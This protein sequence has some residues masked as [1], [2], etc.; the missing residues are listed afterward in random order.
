MTIFFRVDN[1]STLILTSDVDL[2][3]INTTDAVILKLPIDLPEGKQ[4]KIKSLVVTPNVTVQSW[5]GSTL[6]TPTNEITI[7]EYTNQYIFIE[8]EEGGGGY[9]GWS[10]NTQRTELDS[11]L[12]FSVSTKNGT[13]DYISI[14]D[15]SA[16]D[17][18][19][20]ISALEN[21]VYY[22]KKKKSRCKQTIF[23]KF[24]WIF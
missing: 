2:I 4:I 8:I 15:T 9:T 12:G 23:T 13:Y 6:L 21:T 10:A 3:S 18:T 20:D 1:A 22:I 16:G 24:C 17:V 14:I 11:N 7:I 19:I 5:N